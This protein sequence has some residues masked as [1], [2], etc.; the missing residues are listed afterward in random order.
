M[1]DEPSRTPPAS[2][3]LTPQEGPVDGSDQTAAQQRDE[4]ARRLHPD[5][6][7]ALARIVVAGRS[8]D[9]VLLEVAQ[10]ARDAVPG[11]D[12]VSVTLIEDGRAATA[13]HTGP[14]SLAADE[15]QYERGYGPC[16]DAGRVG[17]TLVV[18]D[19]RAEERW[20]DYA[21]AVAVRGVLSSVS[22]PLPVQ[23]TVV[24]ALNVY[25]TRT[26]AFDAEQVELLQVVASYAAVAVANAHAHHSAREQARQLSEAMTS[27]ATIEQAKGI[28]M[29]ERRCTADEAF[30]ILT[31]LSQ[32][33]NRKLRDI[34]AALVEQASRPRDTT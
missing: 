31:R 18:P 16:V 33:T 34:A 22:A 8:R 15:L 23:G 17:L 32:S 2:T 19:M 26:A 30:A 9:D 27:R 1:T 29:G 5:V 28:I 3:G 10:I 6:V 14:L 20:P 24:G 11:A 13:A 12:D 25:S 7:D 4:R 21:Q